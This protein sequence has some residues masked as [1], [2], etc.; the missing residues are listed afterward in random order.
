M[1][2]K[3]L[4][5]ILALVL[6][7]GLALPMAGVVLAAT[8]SVYSDSG[9]DV[10]E[11]NNSPITPQAAVECW[12]HPSWWGGLD[13]TPPGGWDLNAEWIWDTYE[14]DDPS[15]TPI[16]SITGRFVTF[17]KDFTISGTP[18]GGMLYIAVD[19][20]YEVWLNATLVGHDNVWPLPDGITTP[21]PWRSGDLKQGNV[22]WTNWQH[23]SAIDVSALLVNGNNTLIIVAANEYMN[24]DD[25]QP[26]GTIWPRTDG[27][28]QPV[29]NSSN[30]PGGVVFQLDY[31]Y[32]EFVAE[33][34]LTIDKEADVEEALE[35]DTITYTYLVENTGNVPL[36]NLDVTDSLVITVSPKET[37]GFN[38]G[39]TNTDD[40]FDPGEIWEFEAEY[41]VPWF[42]EGP[43]DNTGTANADYDSAPVGPVTD[44]E[45]VDI[46]HNPDIAVRKS[47]P[48]AA[49]EGDTIYYTIWLKN[50]GDCE[51]S[52]HVGDRLLGIDD[53]ITLAPDEVKTYDDIEY[54]IPKDESDDPLPESIKNMVTATG[55]D[56]A[57][58][59]VTA[60]A[61]KTV[62]VLHPAIEVEKA[63]PEY[64]AYFNGSV[65]TY[66]YTV[67]NTGDCNLSDVSL[68]DDNA[69]PGDTS[70]DVEIDLT[71]DSLEP[72]ASATGNA[73]FTLT[74]PEDNYT[75]TLRGNI[76]T[77]EGTDALE[78]TVSDCDCWTVIV[79]QWQPRT[80]GYWGNWENHYLPAEFQALF[81]ELETN[82]PNLYAYFEEDYENVHDLLLGKPPKFKG[83]PVAKAE[84]LME[85]QFL[86]TWLNVKA[87]WE[88]IADD[89]D[90]GL[91]EFPGSADV[92]MDPEATVYLTE[93]EWDD[94]ETLFGAT[95]T[96]MHILTTIEGSKGG[97]EK[98]QLQT[99]QEVLDALNNAED[100]NY[101]MFVHP[102]FD[103][104]VCLLTGD[105]VISVNDGA[106]MHDM[107]ITSQD[108]DGNLNGTGGYPAGGPY[109]ITWAL[110]SSS[111]TDSSVTL[112]LD[113]DFS[114]YWATDTGTVSED[115]NSIMDGTWSDSGGGSGTWTA[116]RYLIE[117]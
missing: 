14:S 79:F 106:F 4:F 80:I 49:H 78:L 99:A 7:L 30:N 12:P 57:D 18:T 11:I 26:S 117:P 69:T 46:L 6:A 86:A 109:S 47:G 37:G 74:C 66:S 23:V 43:V 15:Q 68:V 51:L 8:G 34:S 56:A 108:V 16:A 60:R 5:P 115:C 39:D 101:M 91:L 64:D 35:G 85:K 10:I 97:W 84:F 20:G 92:G 103:P 88:W 42:T 105:W 45:S 58:G 48:R 112:T 90:T 72:G 95:P 22:D 73:Q 52:V 107:T 94:A 44:D 98:D 9:T 3:V 104:E 77:A 50:T 31:E 113:Y 19:N 82:S 13:A 2:R 89:G 38:D 55:T 83:K 102:D 110:V 71:A 70:D 17:Q 96:V 24:P 114:S 76:A 27:P 75:Y 61:T 21:S 54:T 25:T 93:P 33:P 36:D 59:T 40:I 32:E 65:V 29:G 63:G 100:N 116:T 41:T 28:A 111:I 53:N 1:K 62:R 67:T 87:Y 81:D